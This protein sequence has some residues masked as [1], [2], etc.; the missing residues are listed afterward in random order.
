M[1]Y[2][3]QYQSGLDESSMQFFPF[4]Y[5]IPATSTIQ[6]VC[7]YC[8]NYNAKASTKSFFLIGYVVPYQHFDFLAV[9]LLNCSDF[10]FPGII[11][12]Y[13]WLVAVS[14]LSVLDIFLKVDPDLLLDCEQF[15]LLV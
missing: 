8:A 13:H 12:Y 4:W 15:S 11:F 9:T 2:G 6:E 3:G 7:K 10:Y 14:F 1:M 5:G